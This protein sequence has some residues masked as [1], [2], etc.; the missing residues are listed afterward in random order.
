[1]KFKARAPDHTVYIHPP[2]ATNSDGK[3][4][5]VHTKTKFWQQILSGC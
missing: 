5:V 3:K 1:M 4:F 2:E